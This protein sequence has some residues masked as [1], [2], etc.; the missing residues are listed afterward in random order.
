MLLEKFE[1]AVHSLT[2]NSRADIESLTVLAKKLDG[3]DRQR[4][5]FDII[6][7]H[8]CEG[9]LMLYIFD[10]IMKNVGGCYVGLISQEIVKIFLCIFKVVDVQM[11]KKMFALRWTWNNILSSNTLL[12]LDIAINNVDKAWK[13]NVSSCEN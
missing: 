9:L 7:V 5:F 2:S 6:T 12:E 8:C 1:K 13:I 3:Y 4:E 11:R 10:S